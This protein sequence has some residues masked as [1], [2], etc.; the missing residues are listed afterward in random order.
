MAPCHSIA[1]KTEL[2]VGWCLLTRQAYLHQEWDLFKALFFLVQKELEATFRFSAGP[3][4]I[5]LSK[6]SL[7]FFLSFAADRWNSRYNGHWTEISKQKR[8][9]KNNLLWTSCLLYF[10]TFKNLK[11]L[12][13]TAGNRL[14]SV[15]AMENRTHK[16]LLQFLDTAKTFSPESLFL[17][18]LALIVGTDIQSCSYQTK[19]LQPSLSF[20]GLSSGLA[21][22]TQASSSSFSP[23]KTGFCRPD[24]ARRM[25]RFLERKIRKL[26]LSDA[27]TGP[28]K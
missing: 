8:E 10:R 21:N 1:F 18:R 19:C 11:D 22:F 20:S 15:L 28:Q 23:G 16:I 3:K 9:S 13:G 12:T 2:E 5:Y 6:Q 25:Y 27:P 24:F 17:L 26:S 14:V 7:F 4:G